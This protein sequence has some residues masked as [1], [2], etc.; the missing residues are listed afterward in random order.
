MRIIKRDLKIRGIQ[1]PMQYINLLYQ[2]SPTS[3]P[4]TGTGHSLLGT[5]RANA[6]KRQASSRQ[7]KQVKLGSHY[8]LSSA[9]STSPRAPPP[10]H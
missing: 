9:F 1:P 8:L 6:G 3:G 4:R 10:R 2:G 7:H 5:K